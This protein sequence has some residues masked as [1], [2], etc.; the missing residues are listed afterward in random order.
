MISPVYIGILIKNF[1]GEDAVH[2]WEARTGIEVGLFSIS[3]TKIPSTCRIFDN[4]SDFKMS[5]DLW[6]EK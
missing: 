6:I 1:Y 2:V 5:F 3:S 4:I